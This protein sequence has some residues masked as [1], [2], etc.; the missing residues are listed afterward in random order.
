VREHRRLHELRREHGQRQQPRHDHPGTITVAIEPYM[1]YTAEQNGKLIGLDSEIFN[2]IAQQLHQK[3]NVQ[4]T[5]F[6]GMLSGVQTR[7]VDVAIGGIAWSKSRAAVG[8]FTDP[9]YYSPVALA[10][11]NGENITTIAGLQLVAST[12]F[13]AMEVYLVIGVIYFAMCYPLSMASLWLERRLKAGTP[14]SPRRRRL[15]GEVRLALAGT[16]GATA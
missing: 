10:E 5:N 13:R 15:I 6:A 11:K 8:L 14:L 16:P 3:I 9:P 7:R 1:P 4:A 12:T 2:Y